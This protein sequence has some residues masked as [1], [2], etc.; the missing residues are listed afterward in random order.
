MLGAWEGVFNWGKFF[1]VVLS[2]LPSSVAL[3]AELAVLLGRLFP[4]LSQAS[5]VFSLLTFAST[6]AELPG[7]RMAELCLLNDS[8]EG[9]C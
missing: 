9:D 1:A 7:E 2:S 3:F 8:R 5:E 6:S 4:A